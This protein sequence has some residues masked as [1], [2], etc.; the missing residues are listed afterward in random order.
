MTL[1]GYYFT[2]TGITQYA[3]FHGDREL[4]CVSHDSLPD[5]P[6]RIT[7]ASGDV[8]TLAAPHGWDDSPDNGVP[9]AGATYPFIRPDGAEAGCLYLLGADHFAVSVPGAALSGRVIHERLHRSAFLT[10][11]DDEPVARVEYSLERILT[12]ERFGEWFPRRYVADVA[13]QP[14]DT[15]LSLALA[16]PFLGFG[17]L[18]VR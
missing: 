15:L 13:K 11:L 9:I 7:V 8:Y 1:N 4:L 5:A 3:F 16:A 12:R 14:N 17:R 10:D 2:A 6:A 18:E